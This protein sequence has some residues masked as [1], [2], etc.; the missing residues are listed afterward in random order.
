MMDPFNDDSEN[1][2][3][4]NFIMNLGNVSEDVLKDGFKSFENGLPSSD[5]AENVD[6]ESSVWG[7]MPTTF[8]LTNSFDVDAESRQYQDV[9]LDGLRDVDER[10]FFDTSYVQKI[11]SISYLKNLKYNLG[12]GRMGSRARFTI[13]LDWEKDCLEYY[14]NDS[15]IKTVSFNQ[16]NKPIYKTSLN[17][18]EVYKNDLE[19]LFSNLN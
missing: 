10:T 5:I 3:G 17:K 7:R 14:K 13:N 16:A 4:G 1:Q 12:M 6:D 15:P 2:S 18:Y 9:G 11:E 8:A 19:D